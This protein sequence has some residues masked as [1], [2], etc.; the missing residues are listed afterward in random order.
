MFVML[1]DSSFSISNRFFH[2][3]HVFSASDPKANDERF[4]KFLKIELIYGSQ[5]FSNFSNRICSAA[6]VSIVNDLRCS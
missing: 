6:F 5:P 3:W 1:I 4:S 2:D